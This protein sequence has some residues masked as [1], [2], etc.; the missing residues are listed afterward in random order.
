[1]GIIANI[2]QNE[3]MDAIEDIQDI[4]IDFTNAQIVPWIDKLEITINNSPTTVV[5]LST[6]T[7][8]N[9]IQYVKNL[10]TSLIKQLVKVIDKVIKSGVKDITLDTKCPKCGIETKSSV[11]AVSFFFLSDEHTARRLKINKL[12]SI[13]LRMQR[14]KIPNISPFDLMKISYSSL[15]EMFTDLEK[16]INPEINEANDLIKK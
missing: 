1:M 14:V 7:P 9:Q 12:E 3:D 10:P 5:D 13:I 15:N 16:V 4:F 11:P 8:G 2:L 6:E